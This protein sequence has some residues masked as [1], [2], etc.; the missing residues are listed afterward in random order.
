MS[1]MVTN[2]RWMSFPFCVAFSFFLKWSMA[3][4]DHVKDTHR[5]IQM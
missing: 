3:T 1:C 2:V 5:P 4:V